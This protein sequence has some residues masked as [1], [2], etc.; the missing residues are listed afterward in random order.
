MSAER[1][2]ITG[3]GAV[4]GTGMSP[5]AILSAVLEGRSAIAPIQQWDTSGWPVTIAAEMPDFNPRS[6]VEDR[7]LH[8]LIRRTDMFGI[9]AGS[10]AID[11]A[12]FTAHRDALDSAGAATFSDRSGV[13]VG[14]GGGA[15]NTQ[16]EYFPLMSEA[17]VR[18][19]TPPGMS[20]GGGTSS[21]ARSPVLIFC[22]TCFISCLLPVHHTV[23]HFLKDAHCVDMDSHGFCG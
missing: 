6:L 7:K 15:Y 4:C 5:E 22:T 2:F 21:R 17:A 8:K 20:A 11:A 13:Y 16:Y 9:Y 19:R 10:K 18:M 23:M 12:G 1:V 14:S 3:T